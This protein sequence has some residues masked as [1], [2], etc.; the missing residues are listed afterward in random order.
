MY[1]YIL[2]LVAA[3]LILL[4]LIRWIR[5]QPK[6]NRLRY[7][8]YLLI[9]ILGGMALTGRLHWFVV[10]GGVALPFIFK[11][12]SFL[13]WTPLLFGL[14]QRFKLGKGDYD[15]FKSANA[16]PEMVQNL[17]RRLAELDERQIRV[18]IAVLKKKDPRAASFVEAYFNRRPHNAQQNATAKGIT[19]K[20]AYKILGLEAGASR[21]QIID[22]HR[23]LMQKFH[24][25]RG[26]TPYMAAMIN[27]AK[28]LLLE[29]L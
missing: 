27:D 3:I 7:Y 24:P 10:A 1:I 19:T 23:K 12:F 4:L 22:A 2:L 13:R 5:L 25:D 16:S 28:R 8:L 21:E 26:G 11:L 15:L 14:Y 17:L 29:Q 9:A 6:E 18:L 20:E